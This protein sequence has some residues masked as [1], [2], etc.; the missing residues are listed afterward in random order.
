VDVISVVV[1][2]LSL[3][4]IDLVIVRNSIH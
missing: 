4:P 1:L 2:F 3:F